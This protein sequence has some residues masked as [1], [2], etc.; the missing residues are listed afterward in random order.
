MD[1]VALGEQTS[2]LIVSGLVLAGVIS[3]WFIWERDV[4]RTLLYWG[5]AGFTWIWS[6]RRSPWGQLIRLLVVLVVSFVVVRNVPALLDFAVLQHL[7][8]DSGAG[9]R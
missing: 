2:N 1:L 3:A 4:A 6:R 5:M 8:M 9:M 7:P